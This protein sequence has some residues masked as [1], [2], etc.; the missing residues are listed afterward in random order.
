MADGN[1]IASR[2][3]SASIVCNDA[4]LPVYSV[5]SGPKSASCWIASDAGKSFE[6]HMEMLE[7]DSGDAVACWVFV[8]GSKVGGRIL[9]TDE[10]GR[11]RATG[12][13]V[14][15][16][17]DASTVKKLYFAQLTLSDDDAQLTHARGQLDEMGVIAVKVYRVQTLGH[18]E[19]PEILPSNLPDRRGGAVVVHEKDKK[20]GGHHAVLGEEVESHSNKHRVQILDDDKQPYVTLEFRYRPMAILQAQGYVPP[21]SPKEQDR[22]TRGAKRRAKRVNGQVEDRDRP[23]KKQKTEPAQTL[24]TAESHDARGTGSSNA[25]DLT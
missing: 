16:R 9:G 23:P 12:K 15:A 20:L 14:G 22:N 21:A 11:S 3:Y 4:A 8:D 5:D 13:V 17:V 2:G 19:R 1:S 18:A 10:T 6:V 25:I 7:P 24:T